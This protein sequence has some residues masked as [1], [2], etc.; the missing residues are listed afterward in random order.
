IT[1]G[2]A[3]PRLT[4]RPRSSTRSRWSP[5]GYRAN[6]F[7]KR[8]SLTPAERN[9]RIQ[10]NRRADLRVR[11]GR[12]VDSEVVVIH[13]SYDVEP[14]GRRTLIPSP[15]LIGRFT[16][17]RAFAVAPARQPRR[18]NSW[19]TQKRAGRKGLP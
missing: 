3:A 14:A 15:A 16:P 9:A 7:A 19:R 18:C 12:H 6:P 4:A 1:T 11:P 17:L 8:S 10:L 2:P 13:D 5:A